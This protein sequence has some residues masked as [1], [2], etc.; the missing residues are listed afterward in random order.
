MFWYNVYVKKINPAYIQIKDYIINN[1]DSG[2]LKSGNKIETE[3]ELMKRFGVSRMTVNK[4][5][6]LLS[7]EGIVER[8]PGRGTFVKNKMNR[9]PFVNLAIDSMT[10]YISSLNKKPGSNVLDFSIFKAKQNPEIRDIL[11]LTDDDYI[12][13]FA[14]VRTADGEPVV[15]AVSYVASKHTPPL[16]AEILSGSFYKY[17]SENNVTR[18]GYKVAVSSMLA[19]VKIAELLNIKKGD[20]ILYND[21]LLF[22]KDKVPIEYSKVYFNGNM[23]SFQYEEYSD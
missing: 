15:Y 10:D 23:F 1:I 6:S 14:R 20:P 8:V 22:I 17:L 7:T 12:Y 18:S 13:Y 11:N 9:A 19:N 16:S 2:K 5:I 21:G 4:A 3:T